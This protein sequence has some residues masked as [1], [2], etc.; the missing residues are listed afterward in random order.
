MLNEPLTKAAI[1]EELIYN[2]YDREQLEK[3]SD[4]L[5]GDSNKEDLKRL[6]DERA[7]LIFVGPSPSAGEEAKKVRLEGNQLVAA[8]DYRGA[9]KKYTEAIKL[10]PT[11][12]S[13][14]ANRSLASLKLGR[15]AQAFDDAKR[16]IGVDKS[17]AKGYQRLAE[18]YLAVKKY[19]EGYCALKA[20]LMKDPGNAKVRQLAEETW[21]AVLEQKIPLTDAEARSRAMELTLGM[22]LNEKLTGGPTGVASS[23]EE[24]KS[25]SGT[26]KTRAH[27]VKE[28]KRAAG[29]TL[30]TSK[31]KEEVKAKG[32]RQVTEE[33]LRKEGKEE[34]TVRV[35]AE[36]KEY[37]KFFTDYLASKDKARNL[38]QSR[39]YKDAIEVYKVCLRTLEKVRATN[40]TIPKA[41]FESRSAVI[42]NNIAICYKQSESHRDVIN[43]TSKVI[44]SPHAVNELK[45][46]A[47]AFR[48][49]ANEAIGQFP[50]AKNDWMK[51]K[52]LQPDNKIAQKAIDKI[53]S[54]ME[55]G[56]AIQEINDQL[57][58][59]KRKGNDLFKS[60][61]FAW[62]DRKL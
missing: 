57:E 52:E 50:L 45:A 26:G 3:I 46:K 29:S 16:A 2:C 20:S 23:K 9:A 51:V 5:V 41:E 14:F 21:K 62:K 22:H 12:A 47:Y 61:K 1:T 24:V 35:E 8:G 42:N 30:G 43:Y 32:V 4:I 60:S 25:K 40:S 11:E 59:F 31:P 13:S 44:N 7:N 10:D 56:S 55:G 33:Q 37:D 28:E 6:A 15:N 17:Y 18:V 38:F 48:A 19:K 27:E 58:A 36:N 53:N 39:Q 54:N 49:Q 34:K